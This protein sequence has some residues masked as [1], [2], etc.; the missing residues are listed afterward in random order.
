MYKNFENYIWG[1]VGL[2]GSWELLVRNLTDKLIQLKLKPNLT[3]ILKINPDKLLPGRFYLIQ[4][5]FNGNL[6][7]CPILALDYKV[8]K[9][10]HILYAVNLEYLPPR[11]KVLLFDK[12]FKPVADRLENVISQKEFVK[13]EQPLDFINF[14]FM[15]K[16]LKKNGK[17]DFAITA[18]TIKDF[19]GNFKI[20]QSYL[21]SVKIAPEIIMSDF[22]RL[23]SNDM[24]KLQKSLQ[25]EEQIKMTQILEQYNKIIEEYQVDSIAYHKKVALFR[26][27]LK[28]F[29][30]L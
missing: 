17:M 8:H 1:L 16:L 13:D 22:K 30:D 25:G 10:K 21:C 12:I 14:E 6:I 3:E 27:K 7:W 9:N 4:Y 24:L 28:L 11:Y 26:E 5:N 15:Y 19:K 23:N 29:K 20:K 2:N 18:Y